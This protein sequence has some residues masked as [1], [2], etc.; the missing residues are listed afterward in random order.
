MHYSLPYE[1][2]VQYPVNYVDYICLGLCISSVS[3]LLLIGIVFLFVK[4]S[5]DRNNLFHINAFFMGSSSFLYI[6][7]ICMYNHTRL[8]STVS[9]CY[10]VILWIQLV[11]FSVWAST[12]F[13]WT[14]ST[15]SDHVL[16]DRAFL[17]KLCICVLPAILMAVATTLLGH[18][19]SFKSDMRTCTL[20]TIHKYALA[21]FYSAY[22]GTALF[23]IFKAHQKCKKL[24]LRRNKLVNQRVDLDR[25]LNDEDEGVVVDERKRNEIHSA[26]VNIAPLQ[27]TYRFISCVFVFILVYIMCLFLTLGFMVTLWARCL[28]SALLLFLHVF[29]FTVINGD[30]VYYLATHGTLRRFKATFITP[31]SFRDDMTN[32]ILK[33]IRQREGRPSDTVIDLAL[34]VGSCVTWTD[35]TGREVKVDVS[36]LCQMRVDFSMIFTYLTSI[37]N[38]SRQ[39]SRQC[40]EYWLQTKAL[41]VKIDFVCRNSLYKHSL[42]QFITSGNWIPDDQTDA[43]VMAINVETA[44]IHI[45]SFLNDIDIDSLL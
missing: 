40:T 6:G 31:L 44:M 8:L 43:T 23:S 35:N 16:S 11:S 33:Y 13:V 18:A 17:K 29:T 26:S 12:V 15:F 22:L 20:N 37:R 7:S 3:V 21:L 41:A 5:N 4:V 10:V 24:S 30:S 36:N 39:E 42:P 14:Q 45:D 19:I 1:T 32:S 34:R 9:Q 28:N 2:N 27:D 38:C 25:Y